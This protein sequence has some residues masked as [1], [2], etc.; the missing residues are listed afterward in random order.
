MT[1]IHGDN[2]A[3]PQHLDSESVETVVTAPPCY[4]LRDD[5]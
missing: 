1:V 3:E 2:L 4:G 5:G